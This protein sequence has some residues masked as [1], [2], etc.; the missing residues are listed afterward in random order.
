[1]SQF[2]QI[3]NSEYVN[4]ENVAY[5]QLEETGLCIYFVGT[6]NPLRLGMQESS[7]LLQFLRA[8]QVGTLTQAQ[9]FQPKREL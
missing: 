3:T 6:E 5:V 2:L 7:R 1:M 8:R 4:L 9:P